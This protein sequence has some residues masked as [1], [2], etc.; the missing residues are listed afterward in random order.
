MSKENINVLDRI[1]ELL[2]KEKRPFI[3]LT[4]LVIKLGS[5]ARKKLG[6]NKNNTASKIIHAINDFAEDDFMFLK[7][8]RDNYLLRPCMPED[9]ILNELSYTEGKSPKV[10]A[11]RMPFLKSDFIKLINELLEKGDIKIRMS[12]NFE[13]KFYLAIHQEAKEYTVDEFRKAFDVN[14]I[15]PNGSKRIFVR[16]Y[17][18]RNTLN[19]PREVFDKMLKDLRDKRIITLHALEM[20]GMT[21][22]NVEDSFVDENNFRMGTVTWNVR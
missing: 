9:L 11:Q 6:I 7:K 4:K 3:S 1:N 5:E 8:G 21:L 10:I 16:I 19:W 22:K 17:D 12:D 14:N 2:D 13:I 15:L 20:A 18:I